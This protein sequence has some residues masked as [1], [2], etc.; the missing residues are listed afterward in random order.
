MG[1]STISGLLFLLLCAVSVDSKRNKCE[2]SWFGPECQYQCHCKGVCSNNGQCEQGCQKGW[3]GPECQYEDIA[4]LAGPKDNNLTDGDDSTCISD[5]KSRSFTL[6]FEASS[7]YPVTW[8]R[9][10]VNDMGNRDKLQTIGIEFKPPAK[11]INKKMTTADLVSVEVH[12]DKSVLINQLILTGDVVPF[13]CSV[14]VTSGRNVAIHQPTQQSSDYSDSIC[15][16]TCSYSSNAV[17]GSTNTDLY[18]KSCTHTIEENKP[19]WKLN[20]RRPYLISKYKIY[21]RNVHQHRLRNFHI[22][23]WNS[24]TLVFNYTNQGREISSSYTVLQPSSVSDKAVTDIAVHLLQDTK[25]MITICEFQVFGEAVCSKGRYGRD[26]E[27]TCSCRNQSEACL[28]STGGCTSG[29]RDGYI[30]AGCQT[31][32]TSKYFGKDC[33]Q[34][35]DEKCLYQFCHYVNGN[36][37]RCL[38]GRTGSLCDRTCPVFTFGD[39]CSQNCSKNCAGAGQCDPSTGAC[40]SGCKPGYIGDR[41][42]D[43]C[44]NNTYGSDCSMSCSPHCKLDENMPDE[45]CHHYNGH[46][47]HGCQPGYDGWL[48]QEECA[49]TYFGEDCK[50][51]CN[52]N[53]LDQ[54]CDHIS[55]QCL[56]CPAGKSGIFCENGECHAPFYGNNC[57]DQCSTNCAL[58][59]CNS[60]TGICL[61]CPPGKVG[62][63]CQTDCEPTYYGPDCSLRCNKG[64]LNQLCNGTTGFCFKCPTYMTGDHCELNA[65]DIPDEANVTNWQNF[66]VT[67]KLAMK[68]EHSSK[69]LVPIVLGVFVGGFLAGASVVVFI[70]F[71]RYHH[72][73]SKYLLCVDTSKSSDTSDRD[74]FTFEK[75]NEE[76]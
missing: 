61:D 63:M 45:L 43:K 10:T 57:R 62:D 33:A 2:M 1:S 27:L 40:A 15:D 75:T 18:S 46:C 22:T 70:I 48:C 34:K 73:G 23:N 14:H 51:K 54:F 32:C 13:L 6:T 4:I 5:S 16:E 58:R 41:C 9:L 30:G 12:C 59:A 53:C 24:Q 11:C 44:D 31:A 29:C 50:N 3:F 76:S 19:Y 52:P 17:D 36:C 26:C 37:L 28:V 64:C 74:I 20:F 56:V 38:P 71:W 21:N 47:V 49:P 35:C 65:T 25:G 72:I 69:S 55:G 39:A 42:I 8:L 67:E 68:A 60:T 66:S 7:L